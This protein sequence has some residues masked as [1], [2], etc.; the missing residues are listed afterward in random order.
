MSRKALQVKMPGIINP[1]LIMPTFSGQSQCQSALGNFRLLHHFR[2]YLYYKRCILSIMDLNLKT[3]IAILPNKPGVYQ[4]FDAHGDI[5]YVGKASSLKSRVGSYFSKKSQLS[6]AK[7]IM[8]SK[9]A[10]LETIVTSNELEALLLE[11]TLIKKFHPPYNIVMRDD[12]NFLYIKIAL[13]EKFPSVS[14]VRKISKD[15]SRYFGPFVSS[16]SVYE[17]LRLLKK[18]F[19]Y[20]NCANPPEKPCFEY[21]LG[22]CLGHGTDEAS[23]KNYQEVISGLIKF[24]SGNTKEIE[25]NLTRDMHLASTNEQFERAALFRDRLKYINRLMQRQNVVLTS[26]EN[27]DVIGYASSGSLGAVTRLVIRLGKL[28]DKQ[29]VLL[30]HIKD[31]KPMEVLASFVEQFYALSPDLPDK[32]ALPME[33]K[34]SKALVK[35]INAKIFVPIRGRI[36]KLIKVGNLNAEEFLRQQKASFERDDLRLH[37]GLK[38]LTEALKLPAIPKRIE[39]YDVANLQGQHASGSMVV[40]SQGKPDKKFYRRFNIKT[41]IGANDPAMLAEML[42]RRFTHTPSPSSPPSQG[43]EGQGVRGWPMPD[44][45]ILDGGIGQLNIVK[46]KLGKNFPIPIVAIAKGGHHHLPQQA[47][48]EKIFLPNQRAIKLPNPSDGLFLIERIR[49]EAHR[50]SIAGFHKKQVKASIKSALDE[51]PGL[52]PKTKKLLLN[53]F[54]SVTKIRQVNETELA[55][56]VGLKLTKVIQDNL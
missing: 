32:L 37:K 47:E 31:E 54:G 51:I 25:K 8:V 24:L 34:I 38:Q 21:H 12:K 40:F 15:N 17:T 42:G 44:L 26:Q 56:V 46:L 6:P 43:G 41:V 50:F 28:L 55:K 45:I 16:A 27:L 1:M 29:T 52:G 53:K 23:L 14:T 49:D 11:T 33:L 9:I 4:Y 30:Q 2:Q 48:R 18:I 35:I 20:K 3:Q 39:A 5:L 13:A 19:P 10:K 7:A 22:R 36:K